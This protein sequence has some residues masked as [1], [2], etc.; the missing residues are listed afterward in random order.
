MLINRYKQ[1]LKKHKAWYLLSSDERNRLI[2]ACQ[3]QLKF[4]DLAF[5]FDVG[6]PLSNII[7]MLQWGKTMEGI[8]Y[9]SDLYH[10]FLEREEA[11]SWIV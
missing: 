2:N 4:E 5:A 1:L 3:T 11:L 6:Y 9:W 7:M 8:Q 10:T